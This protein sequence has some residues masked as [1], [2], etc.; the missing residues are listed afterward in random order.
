MASFLSITRVILNPPS[1][2]EVIMEMVIVP[3]LVSVFV[4]LGAL[5]L[6]FPYD[7]VLR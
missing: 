6:F 3:L 2:E 7:K 5:I 1:I 4:G